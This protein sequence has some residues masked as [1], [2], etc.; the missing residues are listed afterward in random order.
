MTTGPLSPRCAEARRRPDR[1]TWLVGS[2]RCCSC[3]AT[4]ASRHNQN[5][6]EPETLAWIQARLDEVE[7]PAF[8]CLHHP[9]VALAVPLV[10]GIR[11][12]PL[13]GL[14][15]IVAEHPQVVAVLC[16]HAHTM[17]VTTFAGRPLLVAPGVVSTARR[18]WTT[19]DELTWANAA[20]LDDTP[21]V[22]FHVLD[23]NRR[24]T[25]HFRNAPAA[26]RE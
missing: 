3:C 17:A 21:A 13:G 10:D 16:G 23:D 4:P 18:P 6:L 11:L 26:T 19:A 15:A 20:D 12:E 7:G 22:A 14:A 5:L 24:L 2:A 25:T 8:I 9:P 1:S